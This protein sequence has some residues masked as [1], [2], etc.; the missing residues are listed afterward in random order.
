[1]SFLSRLLFGP[2]ASAASVLGAGAG[3]SGLVTNWSDTPAAL[4]SLVYSD[5]YG[6]TGADAVTRETALTVAPIARG[7]NLIVSK[8]S[9]LPIE[10]G[11]L[12]ADGEFAADADQPEWLTK[13]SNPQS[14]WHRVALTLDDLIFHGWS[15]WVIERDGAGTITDAGRIA[16]HRW[17]FDQSSPTGV[18]V[19]NQQVI[20]AREIALFAGPHEGILITARDSIRGWRR[21]EAAWLG[22]VRNPIPVMVLHEKEPNGVDQAEAV[23]QV[24]AWAAARTSENGAVGWLPAGIDLEVHGEVNADLFTEGR[25]ASRID[26]ANHLSLPVALLDGSPATASLTY[27]TEGGANLQLRDDLETWLAPLESRLSA[28]D[29]SPE[30]K[31]IRFNRSSMFAAVPTHAPATA[32]AQ[33]TPA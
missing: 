5:I 15:L 13:T 1:M 16:R 6:P 33:E 28:D 22:R 8:L 24:A 9:D 10:L 25:N 32:P 14:P 30:G 7:R 18:R 23:E 2:P 26:I 27:S 17:N 3:A 29:L 4:Q 19:D 11:T 20:D 31:V 12:D 21:M